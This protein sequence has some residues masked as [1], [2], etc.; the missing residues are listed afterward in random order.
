MTQIQ[1]STVMAQ[2]HESARAAAAH[3]AS[4]EFVPV[5]ELRIKLGCMTGTPATLQ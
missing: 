1:N 2:G 3:K 5:V 4:A